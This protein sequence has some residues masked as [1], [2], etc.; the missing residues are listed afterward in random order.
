MNHFTIFNVSLH[1]ND[2]E[3]I[4]EDFLLTDEIMPKIVEWYQYLIVDVPAI[5]NLNISNVKVENIGKKIKISF[6]SEDTNEFKDH[7]YQ[8][9]YPDDDG[10]YPLVIDDKEY[11]VSG[12]INEAHKNIDN[13]GDLFDEFENQKHINSTNSAYFYA[14]LPYTKILKINY[15][16]PENLWNIIPKTT[17]KVEIIN[18]TSPI[19]IP[20][21]IKDVKI[22]CPIE[23]V[24]FGNQLE[25]L[26]YVNTDKI[27]FDN[28]F[29]PDTLKT[30][31]LKFVDIDKLVLPKSLKELELLINN[32]YDLTNLPNI[33]N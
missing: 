6:D 19:E 17:E 26:E 7:I 16:V 27:C 20:D 24:K 10:N 25:K 28:G 5:L 8:F 18:L 14:N 31:C 22:Q 1:C 33:K 29:L 12:F 15:Y 21:W 4:F 3:A 32:Y 11:S 30:L 9:V 23:F 2:E 13:E